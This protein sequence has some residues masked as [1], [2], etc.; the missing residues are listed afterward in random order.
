MSGDAAWIEELSQKALDLNMNGLM[1]E[2]HFDPANALCD[3][4]QQVTPKQLGVKF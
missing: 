3:A 1:I 2:C 4:K